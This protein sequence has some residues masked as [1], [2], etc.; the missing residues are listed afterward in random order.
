M[1]RTV[2]A[3]E[4]KNKLGSVVNWVLQNQDDVI[5]ESRGEPTV[6][7]MPY[8]EYE[9]VKSLK[10]PERRKQALERLRKL[11]AEVL[12]VNQDLTPEEGD[13]LAD[14]FT[15]EVIDDLVKEGK[16]RFEE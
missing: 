8:T 15:R 3:S 1:P 7:I 16:I 14:R 12:A 10:E 2:S 11:R 13:A 4:V 9:K 5:V 6:V